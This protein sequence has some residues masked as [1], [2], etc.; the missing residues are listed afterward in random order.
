MGKNILSSQFKSIDDFMPLHA[1]VQIIKS[2]GYAIMGHLI[3]QA[4]GNVVMMIWLGAKVFFLKKSPVYE[5]LAKKGAHIY[6]L[7]N[8]TKEDFECRLST[9][10]IVANRKM[11]CEVWG[12]NEVLN[13]TKN[14]IDALYG[15]GNRR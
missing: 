13:R 12:K 3:Q 7:N 1:Y 8:A 14:V 10:K 15:Y 11:L 5:F 9:E 6:L 2:C 4:V